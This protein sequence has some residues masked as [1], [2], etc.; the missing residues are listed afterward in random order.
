MFPRHVE[1]FSLPVKLREIFL[2]LKYTNRK[3]RSRGR[4]WRCEQGR[5]ACKH[6]PCNIGASRRPPRDILARNAASL[7][8]SGRPI[9]SPAAHFIMHAVVGQEIAHVITFP[10]RRSRLAL[11]LECIRSP[12]DGLHIPSQLPSARRQPALALPGKEQPVETA[13]PGAKLSSAVLH[14]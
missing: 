8:P 11:S 14:P 3:K 7:A 1:A 9:S 13:I 4:R 10:L 5:R 6:R 12:N 2:G